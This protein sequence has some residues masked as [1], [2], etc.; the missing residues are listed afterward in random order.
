[1]TVSVMT[2]LKGQAYRASCNYKGCV[3]FPVQGRHISRYLFGSGACNGRSI[4]CI[5]T[6]RNLRAFQGN[7]EGFQKGQ[8]AKKSL[9]ILNLKHPLYLPLNTH[10]PSSASVSVEVDIELPCDSALLNS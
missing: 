8:T 5:R 4:K 6:C 3:S 2:M 7:I 9:F 10:L 1:M